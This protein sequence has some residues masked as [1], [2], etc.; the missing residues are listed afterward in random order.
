V[1]VE[2]YTALKVACGESHFIFRASLPL[3]WL[4]FA[5]I[6]FT[7]DDTGLARCHAFFSI[8]DKVFAVVEEFTAVNFERRAYPHFPFPQIKAA[9]K[10]RGSNRESKTQFSIIDASAIN[11]TAFV[12]AEP[13]TSKGIF[14]VLPNLQDWVG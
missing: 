2:L 10:P 14:W 3:E 4:D 8:D 7:D 6:K 11:N 13:D 9:K 5:E 1:S 12:I